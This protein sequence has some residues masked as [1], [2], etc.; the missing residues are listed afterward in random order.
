[1]KGWKDYRVTVEFIDKTTVTRT[2]RALSE[3][4]ARWRAQNRD[5]TRAFQ[6]GGYIT[7]VERAPQ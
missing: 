3:A 7:N 4:D 6:M 1:M 2:V 5:M